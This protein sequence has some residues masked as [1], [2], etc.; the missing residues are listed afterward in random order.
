MIDPTTKKLIDDVFG[1]ALWNSY[2]K[3]SALPHGVLM[4][5]LSSISH[6]A[7]ILGFMLTALQLGRIVYLPYQDKKSP[8]DS[9]A[10]LV[11]K[12]VV[13]S[14][15]LIPAVYESLLHY[16]FAMPADAMSNF[17]TNIYVD[18]F[19]KSLQILSQRISESSSN[20]LSLITANLSG[21]V[22]TAMASIIFWAAAICIFIMPILQGT[23]FLYMFYLGP[24]CLVFSLF[25][26]TA[27]VTRAWIS[28]TLTVAWMGFFGSAAFLVADNLGFISNL[29]DSASYS[30][31][32]TVCVYGIISIILFCMAWPITAF[33]FSATGALGGITSPGAAIGGTAAG[34]TSGVGL[35]AATAMMAGGMA[36]ATGRLMVN[37]ASEGGSV[38]KWGKTLQGVGQAGIQHG[39]NTATLINPSM[40]KPA[41]AIGKFLSSVGGVPFKASGGRS[42]TMDDRG[43]KPRIGSKDPAN[44]R[45]GAPII[46]TEKEF[47]SKISTLENAA[48]PATVEDFRKVFPFVTSSLVGKIISPFVDAKKQEN[49]PSGTQIVPFKGESL[50]E[51]KKRIGNI[52]NQGGDLATVQDKA[53]LTHLVQP[54]VAIPEGARILKGDGESFAKAA[55]RTASEINTGTYKTPASTVKGTGED[56]NV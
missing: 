52:I 17:V 26:F 4:D 46:S 24:V 20:P 23:L 39:A 55:I 19:Q 16:V 53:F 18:D 38:S 22:T 28:M 9:L 5:H 29:A 15:L 21:I 27:S 54:G 43:K 8:F 36:A 14:V 33:F 44:A 56:Q 31:I 32:I 34:M 3:V 2:S 12:L 10:P 30:N 1:D 40:Q 49:I 42:P 51:A 48:T 41:N 35:G 6:M 25:D 11:I 7:L 50:F 47:E 13:V 37:N 45:P